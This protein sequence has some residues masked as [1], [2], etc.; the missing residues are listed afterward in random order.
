RAERQVER[1]TPE[2]IGECVDHLPPEVGVR[3]PAVGEDHGRAGTALEAFE[4]AGGD[5]ERD[6]RSEQRRSPVVRG[7]DRGPKRLRHGA[8]LFVWAPPRR[9]IGPNM[10]DWP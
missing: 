7:N 9:R 1:E 8:L 10:T 4:A 3:E 5:V 6:R 2:A